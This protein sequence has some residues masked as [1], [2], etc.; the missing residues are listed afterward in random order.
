MSE[1]RVASPAVVGGVVFIPIAK[2]SSFRY[3]AKNRYWGQ[4]SKEP[5][6]IVV[7]DA[8]GIRA[9]DMEGDERSIRDLL[10]EVAGLEAALEEHCG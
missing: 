1:L 6:A 3:A 10:G 7:C 8:E 5:V 9:F 4:C 2:A